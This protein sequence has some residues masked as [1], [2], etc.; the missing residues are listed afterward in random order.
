MYSVRIKPPSCKSTDVF[1]IGHFFKRYV[2]PSPLDNVPG[3]RSHSVVY[4][5]LKDLDD[6]QLAWKFQEDLATKWGGVVKF[7]GVFNEDMLYVFDPVAAHSVLLKDHLVYEAPHFKRSLTQFLFGDGLFAVSGQRH[8]AQRKMMNPLFSIAQMRSLIPTFTEVANRLK[9][10]IKSQVKD[11]G[12]EIDILNWLSRVALELIGQG[13]LGYSFDPLVE[14]TSNT[15]G[16]TIKR[17]MPALGGVLS[18]GELVSLLDFGGSA[19]TRRRLL[20]LLPVRKIQ[21]TLKVIKILH[22]GCEDIYIKKKRSLQ[23]GDDATVHQVGEGR[24][25]MSVL[26]K[27]NM[28]AS[29]ED[30]LPEAEVIG[31]ICSLVFAA[32]DTTSSALTRTLDL[33]SEHQEVQ[34]KLRKEII[35]AYEV[36]ASELTYDELVELPYLDAICRETLRLHAP[37][38]LIFKQAVQDTVMPLSEPVIDIYGQPLSQIPIPKETKVFLG[39]HASNRNPVLWGDDASEWKPERWLSPLPKKLT[40]SRLPGVYS[41]LLTFSGGGRSCIGFKFSQLEMKVVLATLIRCFKFTPSKDRHN[42]FWNHARI[43]SPSIGPGGKQPMMPMNVELYGILNSDVYSRLREASTSLRASSF[44]L[45][46]QKIFPDMHMTENTR[47]TARRH[48][49]APPPWDKK[50]TQHLHLNASPFLTNGH[51]MQIIPQHRCSVLHQCCSSSIHV[52]VSHSHFLLRTMFAICYLVYKEGKFSSRDSIVCWFND[53]SQLPSLLPFSV[54]WS[55]LHSISF[56]TRSKLTISPTCVDII[57]MVSSFSAHLT[58]FLLLACALAVNAIPVDVTNSQDLLYRSTLA[59]RNIHLLESRGI[60]GFSPESVGLYRRAKDGTPEPNTVKSRPAPLNLQPV[61]NNPTHPPNHAPNV[62]QSPSRSTLSGHTVHRP[63][64]PHTPGGS[65]YSYDSQGRSSLV[66]LQSNQFM[67]PGTGGSSSSTG[68]LHGSNAQHGRHQPPPQ[69]QVPPA[70]SRHPAPQRQQSRPPPPQAP[71]TPSSGKAGSAV[72][73]F[74]SRPDRES[75]KQVGAPSTPGSTTGRQPQ[76]A[77]PRPPRPQE[78][79][80]DEVLNPFGPTVPQRWTNPATKPPMWQSGVVWRVHVISTL[81][82]MG[83]RRAFFFLLD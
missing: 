19:P 76:P 15:L 82:D 58:A 49:N 29:E 77:P 52:F 27:A 41:H 48:S 45:V 10:A 31:Q 73:K 62:P 18:I 39:V 33:L 24:D 21:E 1:P 35:N 36:S 59:E 8:R 70:G 71:S 12:K 23:A 74:F 42:V 68:T 80:E 43:A 64:V 54:C 26:L 61:S 16:D 63:D 5:N 7:K 66:S 22:E 20:G 17:F 47:K 56:T 28:A 37:V 69:P 6:P 44:S 72:K 30:R 38:S 40:D 13:G 67:R 32:A 34:E 53:S 25:I 78:G 3:P 79:L 50:G 75:P 4:G 83:E 65:M 2:L 9:V 46:P 81:V 60:D 14:K 51:L 57:P 55:L 11:G